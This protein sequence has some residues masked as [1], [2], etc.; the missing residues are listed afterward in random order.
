M[1]HTSNTKSQRNQLGLS[2]V[3]LL[4]ALVLSLAVLSALSAVYIAA[5]QAFKFQENTGRMQED[6]AF[7]L[8]LLSR[9]IRMTGH[10]GCAGIKQ[11]TVVGP[12]SVT[13]YTPGFISNS[14]TGDEQGTNPMATVVASPGADITAQPYTANN[15]IRGFDTGPNT[16]FATGSSPIW[17]TSS[18]SLFFAGA[19]SKSASLVVPMA[20]AT[21]D[22]QLSTNTFGWSGDTRD[23]IISDCVDST[24]FRG[25]ITTTGSGATARLNIEHPNS[26]NSLATF[27]GSR[28]YG[29]DAVVMS[30]YWNFVFVAKRTANSPTPSL[31][32]VFHDGEDRKNA[33]EIISNVEAMSIHYGE[34]TAANPMVVANWRTTSAAVTDWSRIV[35]VRVGLMMV[36]VDSNDSLEITASAITFLGQAYTV[37]TGQSSRSRREFST[38]IVLRNRVAP[39]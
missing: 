16:M 6:A 28:V 5:K 9:E 20:A 29:T 18:A 32:R 26:V 2:L 30:P 33:E 21:S 3:E 23:L 19:N 24:L 10:A 4:I 27:K 8:E 12:P 13:T 38:T 37:P 35:A 34:A 39:R 1:R 22:L 25:V 17:G 7:A 36:G 15:V 14:T 11:T 31:Y